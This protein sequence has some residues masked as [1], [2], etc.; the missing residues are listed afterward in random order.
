MGSATTKYQILKLKSRRLTRGGQ[1]LVACLLDNKLREEAPDY[2][3][4]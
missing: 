1:L 2:L 4:T 3:L